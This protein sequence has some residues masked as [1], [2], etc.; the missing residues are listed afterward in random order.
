MSKGRGYKTSKAYVAIFVCMATKA[1]HIE[2]VS[3]IT[4]GAFVAALRRMVARRGMIKNIYSDNG[5]C[6]V[7]ANKDL[8]ELDQNEAF[9]NEI[10][11]ELANQGVQWHFSPAAAPHFNG[12][13]EAGVKSVKSFLKKSM[14]SL[15]LTFEELVTLLY[16]IEA[17]VNSR[18]LTSLS[19]DPDDTEVLTP[20]HFLVGKPLLAPPDEDFGESNINW[21]SR[22]QIVQKMHQCFWKR[23]RDEYFH[24]LQQKNKWFEQKEQLKINELVLVKDDNVAPCNWP[25]ARVL[26]I[27]SGD[28]NL[29]RVVTLKMKNN[30]FKRPITRLAPLPIEYD[31]SHKKYTSVLKTNTKSY[32]IPIVTA[33]F[34]VFIGFSSALPIKTELSPFNVSYFDTPPG[35]Y[36]EKKSTAYMA[37]ASWNVVS[38]I[39]LKYFFNEFELIKNGTEKLRKICFETRFNHRRMISIDEG[40]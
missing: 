36:F 29:S 21:L 13:A 2:L 22:W 17:C 28:D 27:H 20:G 5:T 10:F 33:L 4:A 8:I 7:K 40:C 3:D 11:G 12:L 19:S 14:G 32:V 23:F 16:Q 39:D 1:V 31:E 34:A 37:S 26:K 35:L 24:E 6:F 30:I 18:P 38:F 9:R 15:I 25:L